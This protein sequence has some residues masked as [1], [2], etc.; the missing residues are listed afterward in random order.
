MSFAHT[1][2]DNGNIY[3]LSE[4]AGQTTLSFVRA[5]MVR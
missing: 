1:E 3:Y 2:L 5:K 4:Y